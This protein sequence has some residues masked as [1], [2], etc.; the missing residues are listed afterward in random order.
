M[1]CQNCGCALCAD[2][3]ALYKRVVNRGATR[4]SCIHCLSAYF[5][6]NEDLLREKIQEFKN[7]G[8]TLFH[9]S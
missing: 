8:C 5:E 3:V 4:F 9:T 6:V 1:I 7:M 2:E